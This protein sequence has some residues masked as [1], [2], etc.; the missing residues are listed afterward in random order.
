METSPNDRHIYS[1]STESL[2]DK[3]GRTEDVSV[4]CSE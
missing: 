3:E 2:H 4:R 1:L